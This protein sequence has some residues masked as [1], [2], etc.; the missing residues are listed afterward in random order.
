MKFK[1]RVWASNSEYPKGKMYYLGNGTNFLVNLNGDVLHS[2]Y[3]GRNNDI[4]WARIGYNDVVLMQYTGLNDTTRWEQLRSEEQ[5]R[6][7][8]EGCTP[9]EW[10]GKEIYDGDIVRWHIFDIGDEASQWQTMVIYWHT[11][12]C[13]WWMEQLTTV[14]F[15]VNY[16]PLEK[17]TVKKGIKVIDNIYEFLRSK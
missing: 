13:A 7:L 6:W 16:K 9:E 11:D 4:V 8:E 14:A 5:Q 2:V 15:G 3:N 17:N 12:K 1:F 10:R